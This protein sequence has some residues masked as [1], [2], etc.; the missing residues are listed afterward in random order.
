MQAA[1]LLNYAARECA[2]YDLP[3][4]EVLGNLTRRDLLRTCGA[5]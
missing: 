2:D 1:A 3:L 4:A 5:F